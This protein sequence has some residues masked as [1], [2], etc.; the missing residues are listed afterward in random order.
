MADQNDIELDQFSVDDLHALQDRI[1]GEIHERGKEE[2][3][4]KR[5]QMRELAKE[6][7]YEVNPKQTS[8]SGGVSKNGKRLGR[9]PKNANAEA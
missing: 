1:K 4:E 8:Q 2:R 7:G 6:L 9:P 3:R 5:R